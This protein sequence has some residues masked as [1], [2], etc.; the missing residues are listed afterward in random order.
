V[1]RNGFLIFASLLAR[2]A[3]P[4]LLAVGLHAGTPYY[5]CSEGFFVAMERLVS[6]H[7]DSCVTLVAPFLRWHKSDVYEYFRSAELPIDLTYSCEAGTNPPC[8][9]CASC[10]DRRNLAC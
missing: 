4:G 9:K 2:G 10:R 5:D 3:T 7:T 8:E 6:E 1:G